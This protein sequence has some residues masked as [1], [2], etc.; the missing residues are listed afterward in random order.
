VCGIAGFIAAE[1]GANLDSLRDTITRMTN[2]LSHRGPD[3]SGVWLDA[4]VPVALGHR[5]LSII[6]LSPRGHQPMVSA[7]G[8]RVLV[9]NGEIY[10]YEDLRAGLTDYP[11]NG[12]SDTEVMLAAFEKYG[13]QDSLKRFNGMF[14]FALWDRSE[15]IL[16]LACDRFGEKPLYYGFAGRA[17][18]FGSELKALTAHPDF[19]PAIARNVVPLFLRYGYVPKPWSIY[20]NARKLEPGTCMS[21]RWANLPAC[22]QPEP[23]W[24]ARDA[25]AAA[26][27]HPFQG[28]S[29]DAADRLEQ[30]LA[31]SVR[32][33]MVADVP[34]GAFLSGGID[35][36]TMV[37]LMQKYG[38][39]PARTFTIGFSEK[40]YNEANEARAVARRLGTDHTELYVTPADAMAVIPRLSSIYDE[41]FADSSQVP[42]FLVSELARRH[43]AVAL[44]GDGGDEVFGGYNRY[45]WAGPVW[46]KVRR[47]PKSIRS[48]AARAVTAIS[49][50]TWDRLAAFAPSRLAV[51]SPGNKMHKLAGILDSG[52]QEELYLRLKSQWLDPNSVALPTQE[53]PLRPASPTDWDSPGT[54]LQRMMLN[55]SVGYLPDDILVKVDRAAMAVSLETRAPWL[56][57]RLFEFVWSLPDEWKVRAGVSKWLL[58]Q[59]LY[60]YVPR[61]MMERPKAGFGIPLGD[62]IR[63]PLRD[64]A[65]N[66]LDERRLGQEGFLDPVP[67]RR[68][69]AQHLAGSH[70]W[71]PQL[72]AVLMFED[73]LRTRGR[74]QEEAAEMPLGVTS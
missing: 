1:L 16:H 31:D 51:Q 70:N 52:S 33:R 58:R 23:F 65:E 45:V 20:R 57:H 2:R 47:Y 39:Q 30:L 10:N 28:T 74:V 14:A 3:D 32:M 68:K 53:L 63:G 62:W 46:E 44:S 72:W 55:D 11:F 19:D 61:E 15:R 29:G 4:A 22:P 66:L 37:A 9:F 41:P 43:V 49:P 59:V 5:R 6:D 25:A 69:W 40:S 35:S 21:I 42:T 50:G 56:D 36:T 48:V 27:R 17:L 64:W 73:W 7:D 67:I 18:L 8:R 12:T 38:S 26:I 71:Y 13:I 24:S 54:C 60:R 34:L